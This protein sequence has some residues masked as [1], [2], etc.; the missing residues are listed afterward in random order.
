MIYLSSC[1]VAFKMRGATNAILSLTQPASQDSQPARTN[2]AVITHSSGNH[3]QALS[4]AARTIGIQAEVIMPSTAP[5]VKRAAVEGYGARVTICEP[6]LDARETTT[7]RRIQELEGEGRAVELIPPYDD[8]RIVAGQGT[9][10]LELV[11]QISQLE[12]TLANRQDVLDVLVAPVGG[13]GLL[14]G[15]AVAAKGLIPDVAVVGAEPKAADDA[16]RGFESGVWVPSVDPTTIADGLKTSTG[17]LTFPLIREYVD[18]IC[19]VEEDDIMCVHYHRSR[20]CV[21]KLDIR[22]T[23]DEAGLRAHEA[24]HRAKCGCSASC[25][26]LFT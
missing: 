4:Y 9:H 15:T 21:S 6:T 20:I 18:A 7:Q 11:E 8:V 22:Q 5:S 26:P 16:K 10:V 24:C 2:M 3:A 1:S 25:C 23:G 12:P 14:S 13:G 17:K 19:T